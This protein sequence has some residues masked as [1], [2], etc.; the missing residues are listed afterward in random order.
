MVRSA[1]ERVLLIGDT[2]RQM[3]ST[4]A[5][6]LPNAQVKSVASLFDGIAELS[7]E[8]YTTV[9]ASV[10]PMERRP[11]SAVRTLRE[12]SGEGRLFLFG[13]PTLEPLS[14]KMMEFGCDDYLITPISPGELLETLGTA[15]PAKKEAAKAAPTNGKPATGEAVAPASPLTLVSVPDFVLDA[16]IMSPHDPGPALV[17]QINSILPATFNLFLTPGETAPPQPA[18]GIVTVSHRP[19]DLIPSGEDA[20]G[21]AGPL[22]PHLSDS[23]HLSFPT[24]QDRSQ[25][26]EFLGELAKNLSRLRVL[27]ERHVALQRLAVTDEL[28]GLA[29][30]RYFKQ[31]L[32]QLVEKARIKRFL[33]TLFLFDIDNF[34]RYNDQY[35]HGVGDDILK[36]TANL[37]RRCVRDHDLVSRIS[38]DEFAVVFWDKEGPRMPRDPKPNATNRTPQ[39]PQDILDRFRNLLSTQDYPGLG[40]LGKGCLTISG[41]IAVFPYDAQDVNHLIEAA[42]RQLMFGAKRS[43]RNSIHLVGGDCLPPIAP[44]EQESE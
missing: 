16:M 40:P 32:N 29:N 23:V 7:Q 13:H 11:E 25:A 20:G 24:D 18:E 38:G 8:H 15:S 26:V 4:L 33:V 21:G 3:Y 31:F 36:Q 27:H 43:G 39:E 41:G 35:G 19:S 30:S 22:L 9:L 34:K 5:Q 42:D 10:E 17:R 1:Q 14:Q 12:L 6:A 2:D 28:T 37:M 44:A